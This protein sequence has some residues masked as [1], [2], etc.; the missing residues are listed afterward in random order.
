MFGGE[1]EKRSSLIGA[2][3]KMAAVI[4]VMS[5]F[6]ASWLST[7]TDRGAVSQLAGRVRADEPL[8]T[9][10]IGSRAAA[11]KLDPCVAPRR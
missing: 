6:V 4:G 3:I 9:G 2:T 11:T 8:T 1:G 10:S 5:W 7:A